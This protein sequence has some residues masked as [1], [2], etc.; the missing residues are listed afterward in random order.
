MG[1]LTRRFELW[2]TQ[3]GCRREHERRHERK[4]GPDGAHRELRGE[5][6]L[7]RHRRA[8]EGVG[9]DDRRGDLRAE[10]RTY[11]SHDRVDPG[12]DAGLVRA[13]VVDGQLPDRREAKAMPMPSRAIHEST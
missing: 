4:S 11:R 1:A 8:G 10:R 2:L 9:R 6:S 12:G 3:R 7:S 13:R 5:T